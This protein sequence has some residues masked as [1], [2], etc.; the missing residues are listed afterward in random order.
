MVKLPARPPTARTPKSADASW[1][2]ARRRSREP[3]GEGY[4]CQYSKHTCRPRVP[5]GPS[6]GAVTGGSHSTSSAAARFSDSPYHSGVA[7]CGP[8]VM[9]AA[10]NRATV[11][12]SRAA[13]RHRSRTGQQ[14][15]HAVTGWRRAPFASAIGPRWQV[16]PGARRQPAHHGGQ[17]GAAAGG[18]P[19]AAARQVGAGGR[20]VSRHRGGQ[21]GGGRVGGRA[22][23]RRRR[24]HN[25][26]G[27]RRGWGGSTTG[28][29]RRRRVRVRAGWRGDQA[30]VDQP[31]TA[32]RRRDRSAIRAPPGPACRRR[33]RPRSHA[34]C[35]RA[36]APPGIQASHSAGRRRARGRGGPPAGSAPRRAAWPASP[37]PAA[38][39]P[40]L[41]GRRLGFH[42]RHRMG[43]AA[44]A[45]G[46]V[47]V[48]AV[49]IAGTATRNGAP[50]RNRHGF[51]RSRAV[52]GSHRSGAG[53]GGTL[54]P[55][56]GACGLAQGCSSR[57][58]QL[59]LLN[60][61]G[62]S[63]GQELRPARRRRAG[64]IAG[65]GRLAGAHHAGALR[66]P[67]A[68]GAV[69]KLCYQAGR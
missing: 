1:P 47:V 45:G 25:G 59:Q 69:A 52:S 49:P 5:Q 32:G 56:R 8:M 63:P 57:V 51:A 26:R 43:A 34:R 11:G 10:A 58:E 39:S 41:A 66:T 53:G 48:A 29:P 35:R 6:R 62:Q 46:P 13:Q 19:G 21:D 18:R 28:A 38:P 30:G 16:R 15:R 31:H 61:G 4:R 24:R 50:C 37:S 68:R 14:A 55:L 9:P 36:D 7:V 12:A 17:V 20:V 33:R 2:T 65:S 42:Q 22:W 54:A 44:V 60:H 3:P 40:W 27:H 67:P 23:F 64:R